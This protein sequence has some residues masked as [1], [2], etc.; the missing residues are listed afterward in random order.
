MTSS[1]S[2]RQPIISERRPLTSCGY[3]SLGSSSILYVLERYAGGRELRSLAGIGLE[4]AD[5]HVALE[6]IEVEKVTGCF[7]KSPAAFGDVRAGAP[8]KP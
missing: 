2:L 1:G 7:G 4:A 3:R 6:R 5:N 8:F